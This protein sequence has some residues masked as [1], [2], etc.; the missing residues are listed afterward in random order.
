MYMVSEL[1]RRQVCQ[2]TL[3]GYTWLLTRGRDLARANMAGANMAGTN[4]VGANGAGA[5]S[6][7]ACAVSVRLTDG[8]SR[9]GF[10][11]V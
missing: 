11:R 7:H 5:R 8:M 3:L 2:D 1:A 6:Q 10:L 9:S 4:V